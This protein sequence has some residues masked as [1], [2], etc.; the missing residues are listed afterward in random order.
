MKTNYKIIALLIL[1][2]VGGT[3]L[4][5]DFSAKQIMVLTEGSA[6][7]VD[8][9]WESGDIIFYEIDDELFLLNR[10]K[11]ESYG[12]RRFSHR[13]MKFK[14]MVVNGLKS[15][16]FPIYS[17]EPALYKFLK[18]NSVSVKLNLTQYV[19]LLGLLIFLSVLLLA[20]R[21]SKKKKSA[22]VSAPA[23]APVAAPG[24]APIAAVAEDP[25][26]SEIIE[27]VSTRVEIVCFFLNLFK[28]QV[29]AG[30]DAEVEYER[31]TSKSPGPNDIYELRV[32]KTAD[33][34][35]R[36]MSIG[37]LGEESGSKSEC[38]YVIYDVHM[39][40]KVPARPIIDFELYIA[41]IE[42]EAHIVN[43]L[44]PKECIVPKVSVVLGMIHSLPQA[45]DT[46]A[47]GLEEK[48]IE[49]LRH[50]PEYQEYLKISSTFIYVMDLSKY[51]FLSH[52]LDE[53]HDVQDLISKEI[54]ENASIIWEP[55][56]FVGRYGTENDAL[57]EIRDI[58]NGCAASI[59][60]LVESTGI[61]ATISDY[62]IQSWFIS[63]L[64][65]GTV[66]VNGSG[67]PEDFISNLNGL[68]EKTIGD[69]YAVFEVYRKV[70]KD[71]IYRSFFK[72]NKAPMEAISV[73]LLD[74]L[75]WFQ[76]KHVSMRDL[77]PDNLFVA[78][79]NQRYPLFLRSAAEF[80]LGIIDVE[81][82][83][84]FEKPKYLKNQQPLLGGTPFYATPSH[85]FKNDIL[86]H[87][88]GDVGK[89]LHLQD[90][91]AIMVMIYK[92]I[93]GEHLFDQTAK[94]FA[95]IRGMM[96]RANKVKGT[97]ID[98]IVEGTSR[99][100]WYSAASEFQV[101][102]TEF[103]EALK[104]IILTIPESVQEMFVRVLEEERKS[105]AISIKE[106]VETQTVFQKDQFRAVLLKA[107]HTKTCQFKADLVSKAKNSDN[108]MASRAEAIIFLSKLADLKARFGLHVHMQKLLSQPDPWLSAH[109]VLTFMFNV[110]L[111]N[112]YKS[113]WAPLFGE[114]AAACE[115]TD[116]ETILAGRTY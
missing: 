91:H 104:S 110:V 56:K 72:Q 63:H 14:M 54:S 58:Y 15:V 107:S 98:T 52:I 82:A 73:N 96:I 8:K 94:L 93:I 4:W 106:C 27:E 87:S 21:I 105:A 60:R 86:S 18:G 89:I 24:S 84:D 97:Q 33:W 34:A 116:G 114:S 43:K 111:N 103:A 57:F 41:S 22:P 32:K 38:Y 46:S 45:E 49:W 44:I 100:F 80:S 3:V 59:R 81:T 7:M 35:K 92:V 47:E 88:F 112:M 28:Q 53:L 99:T 29:D 75:A 42:K 62:Q 90:W 13:F 95:S 39:V 102:T 19:Y 113:H 109:D 1:I 67:Y 51:Y 76:K 12:K 66:S 108:P 30:P 6:K 23:S 55:T 64:A 37:P 79:D 78:G 50:S 85:F 5:L 9:I 48:Y 65:Q 70:V 20:G 36:R 2:T 10:D 101:K 71:Y 25:P 17:I 83:V 68:V 115:Q 40:I 61:T 74:I 16:A 26:S 11:V 77:K 69:N 31:L